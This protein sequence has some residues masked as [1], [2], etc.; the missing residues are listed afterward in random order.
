MVELMDPTDDKITTESASD[1][2][3]EENDDVVDDT[4]AFVDMNDVVEVEVD[5][6]APMMEEDEEMDETRRCEIFVVVDI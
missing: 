2:G 4:P 1:A 5:D 3:I 6:D